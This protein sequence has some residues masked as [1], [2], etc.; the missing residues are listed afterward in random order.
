MLSQCNPMHLSLIR[1]R[2]MAGGDGLANGCSGVR[3]WE[4]SWPDTEVTGTAWDRVDGQLRARLP[5]G[6][7]AALLISPL[8]SR[9]RA[10]S[11]C[12]YFCQYIMQ[13]FAISRVTEQLTNY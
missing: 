2:K 1:A 11:V 8:S 4:S 6:M 7:P 12:C 13:P 9:A 3:S 10:E 5:G